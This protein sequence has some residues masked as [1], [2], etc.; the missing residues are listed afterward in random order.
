MLAVAI[1]PNT[2]IYSIS[3]NAGVG[4]ATMTLTGTAT[5]ITEA[6]ASGNYSFVYLGNGSYTVTPSLGTNKFNPTSTNVTVSS[7]NVTGINFT[8]ANGTGFMMLMGCGA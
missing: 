3:G 7:A 2:S 4:G 1:A 6:D 8:L 5:V